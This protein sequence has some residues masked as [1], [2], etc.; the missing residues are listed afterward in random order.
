[1]EMQAIDSMTRRRVNAV[2]IDEAQVEPHGE[3]EIQLSQTSCL[4]NPRDFSKRLVA[5]I[6]IATAYHA[7][8]DKWSEEKRRVSSIITNNRHSAATPEDLAQLWNV[9][10]QTA[11]DMICI[12]TQKGIRTAIHPMT[13]R[14]QVDH[15]HLHRQRLRGTWYTDTLLSKVK[16]KLGSTCASVYTQ[17]KFTRVIPMTSR[18]DAGESLIDLMDDVGIPEQLVTGGATEFTGR[19]TEFVKEA[20]RMR[21]MLHTTEKRGKRTKITR[22]SA[23]LDSLQS[24]G[25]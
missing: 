5:F 3:T 4:Y 11:K 8:I 24:D 22:L 20:W 13:R 23:R 12:T 1:M 14:V 21:I 6:N 10:L 16:S 15:L 9:G 18:K 19:H 7:D 2:A 17:G 25:S